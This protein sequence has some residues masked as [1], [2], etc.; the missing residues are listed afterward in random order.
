MPS[1]N[2]KA[3]V[4]SSVSVIQAQEYWTL[5]LVISVLQHGFMYPV[6]LVIIRVLLI[7]EPQVQEDMV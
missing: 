6:Y 4:A 7:K 3:L 5:V 2:F 1:F